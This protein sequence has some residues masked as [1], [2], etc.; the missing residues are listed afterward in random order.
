MNDQA[1]RILNAYANDQGWTQA[2]CLD[3]ALE[4]IDNQQ[5]PQ[6]WTDFLAERAAAVSD[7]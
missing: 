1:E 3:L 5:S 7:E 6:A 4:Y 2:T